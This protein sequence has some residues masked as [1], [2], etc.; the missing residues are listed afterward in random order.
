[1]N[2]GAGQFDDFYVCNALGAENNTFLGDVVIQTLNPSADGTSSQLLG[3]D[4]NSVSN[5]LLVDE[6]PPN[7]TDYV[8]SATDDLKDTY[9]FTNLTGTPTSIRAVRVLAY[10][11]KSDAGTKSL[12]L[13]TRSGGTEAQSA[14]KPLSMTWAYYGEMLIDD[15]TDSADWTQAKVDGA[16][17]G[18]KV[19]P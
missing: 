10:A 16:E 11:A 13:V 14:D 6:A 17:F 5:Y 19:R 4:G 9:N 7:T 18:V 12:A 8:G 15:P 1:V 3:S 2:G